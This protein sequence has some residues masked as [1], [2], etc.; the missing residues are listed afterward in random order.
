VAWEGRLYAPDRED[1]SLTGESGRRMCV[2]CVDLETGKVLWKQS[3]LKWPNLVA[4]G[5]TLIVMTLE[6]ELIFAEASPEAWKEIARA[7]ALKGPVWSPPAL[8]DGLLYCRNLMGDL[9]CLDLRAE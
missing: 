4:A 1:L 2:K 9:V 8:A 3:P 6:G 5:G 7:A